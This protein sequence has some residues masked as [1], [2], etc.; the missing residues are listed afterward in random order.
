M[1]ELYSLGTV[2]SYEKSNYLIIGYDLS[3]VKEQMEPSYLVVPIP[4]GYVDRESIRILPA[5]SITGKLNNGYV[6]NLGAK[7]LQ[8]K[9]FNYKEMMNYSSAEWLKDEEEFMGIIEENG[10]KQ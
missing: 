4:Y 8:N 6:S 10:V 3:T 2:V 9:E 5:S 7:Y 1:N